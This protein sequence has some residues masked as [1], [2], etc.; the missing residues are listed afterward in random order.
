MT[1]GLCLKC[2][3][4]LDPFLRDQG[5]EYHPTC[6]PE[7]PGPVVFGE[8]SG[9]DSY[10]KRIRDDLS[11]VIRWAASGSERSQQVAV[12]ASELGNECDR[13]LAYRIAGVPRINIYTDPWPATVGTAIHQWLE[14]AFTRF[15]REAGATRWLIEETV[16]PDP[17]L[18]S[19]TDVFDLWEGLVLDWKTKGPRQMRHFQDHGPSDKH[20]DQVHLYGKGQ[21]EAGRPVE[22]VGIVAIPRSG[23]LSDM[24]VWVGVYDEA[25]ADRAVARMYAI[26]E[27]CLTLDVT[28]HPQRF[29]D[30]QATS[31]PLCSW[32]PHYRGRREQDRGADGSGC[33]GK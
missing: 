23:W 12:G 27:Q 9:M 30:I 19:H 22:R 33:P 5:V 10:A 14:E 17:L 3:I 24:E 2:G 18:R 13:A 28:A 25:R 15:Q 8:L 31:S 4:R 7:S 1:T 29:Q 32:C 20:V 26:G 16:H 6:E 11:E 21:R